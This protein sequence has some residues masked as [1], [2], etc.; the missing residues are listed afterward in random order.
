MWLRRIVAAIAAIALVVGAILVRSSIDDDAASGS[1]G[2]TVDQP[3]DGP[4]IAC[5]TEL[6]DYCTQLTGVDV[7]VESWR[8]TVDSLTTA[9][10]PDA[11]VTFT[12]LNTLSGWT[13]PPTALAG[14]DLIVVTLADRAAAL[15]DGC[16]GAEL[17]VCVGTNAGAPWTAVG[18]QPSWGSIRPGIAD[19]TSSAEGLLS[20]AGASGAFFATSSFS[21][22]EIEARDDYIEWVDRLVSAVPSEA[23]GDPL[24]LLLQRPSAVNVVATTAQHF[25]TVA[26]SRSAQF[27]ATY[28]G[29][30]AHAEV[31]LAV[32]DGTSLG[33]SVAEQ[34]TAA[35][36][37]A[38]WSAA[39]DGASAL[40]SGA[41]LVRLA[42]VWEENR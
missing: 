33:G 15:T 30:M 9:T 12:P 6:A 27:T 17:W 3:G 36:S 38:G 19:P 26:G 16:A 35:L 11:W 24:T 40:P 39:G 31:V 14:S 28:P 2:T 20:L 5:L 37:D 25:A 8:S 41:T 29:P 18:G 32:A 22:R 7:R 34:L 13:E 1:D 21:S 42:E 10:A 23:T 4:V